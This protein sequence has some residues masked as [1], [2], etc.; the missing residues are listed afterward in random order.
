MLAKILALD[1]IWAPIDGWFLISEYSS[2]VSLSFF[3]KIASGIPIFPIS[4]KR[5]PIRKVFK[6]SSDNPNFLPIKT[7]Y[8]ATLSEWPFVYTSLTS[9]VLLRTSILSKKV[10]Y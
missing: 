2:S 1:N 9:T 5:A 6:S 8:S 7:E 4:W 10:L 3:N